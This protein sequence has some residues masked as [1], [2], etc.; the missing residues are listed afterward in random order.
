VWKVS[1]SMHINM[2]WFRY[3]IAVYPFNLSYCL[4]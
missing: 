4:Y 3:L 2:V 1:S